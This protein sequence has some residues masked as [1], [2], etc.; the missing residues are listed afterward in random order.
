[1]F[2]VSLFLCCKTSKRESKDHFSHISR[3]IPH[4][5]I[6]PGMRAGEMM[7]VQ[8]RNGMFEIEVPE[9]VLE[10]DEIEVE[11]PM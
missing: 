6:P 3:L 4:T 9:G 7:V 5:L 2:F 1:M 10:G 8:L 11:L